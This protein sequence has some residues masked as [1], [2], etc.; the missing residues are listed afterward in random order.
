MIMIRKIIL[1]SLSLLVFSFVSYAQPQGGSI[2]G[3]VFD[4]IGDGFPFVNVALYQSGNLRGGATTDFNGAFKISNISAGTYD[5][6]IHKL[7]DSEEVIENSF[8]IQP[9]ERGHYTFSAEVYQPD[10][11]GVI[12]RSVT[13]KFMVSE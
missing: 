9:V 2:K 4:E 1:T 5:L 13:H 10:S 12:L 8:I 6:E 3:K 7:V 11:D